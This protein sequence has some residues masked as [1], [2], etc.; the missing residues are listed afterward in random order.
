[1]ASGVL[2]SA[3]STEIAAASSDSR[4]VVAWV[5]LSLRKV[6]SGSSF[7]GLSFCNARDVLVLKAHRGSLRGE[8]CDGMR[9]GFGNVTDGRVLALRQ[10]LQIDLEGTAL[11][12][13]MLRYD[14]VSLR[15]WYQS[16]HIS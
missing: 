15:E 11:E 2:F 9:P 1:M 6:H 3:C 8:Y 10:E 7:E 13:D 4:S 14:S 5:L 16:S 12:N